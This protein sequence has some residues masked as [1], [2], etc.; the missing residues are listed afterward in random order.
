[1]LVAIGIAFGNTLSLI[2]VSVDGKVEVIAN[3]DGDRSIPLALL[4]VDGDEYHG[5]QA[6]AQLVRNP[7]NTVI[8]FR[9]LVGADE[10]HL[11]AAVEKADDRSAKPQLIDGVL[12]YKVNHEIVL[13]DEICARHFKQLKLAA[14]DYTGKTVGSVVLTVPTNFTAAQRERLAAVATGAGLPVAQLVLEPLAA[15]LA[16]V[17][18]T[19]TLD[20]DKTYVVADFGGV[21]SDAAV[22]AVRGGILTVLATAHDLHLGGALL[23]AALADH[24]AKEFTKK[25]KADARELARLAAKL[26][27]ECAAVK[28]TLLNVLTATIS[29]DLLAAGFDFHASV[30]RL[31]YELL[32]RQPLQ[33]MA[34]FVSVC[35]GKADLEPLDIDAVLL[36]GGVA[37][38]PKLTLLVGAAFEEVLTAVVDPSELNARGAA[39]QAA[40]IEPFDKEEIDASLEPV[41]VNSLH[42]AKPLGL[43]GADG[44][45]LPVVLAETA[46]PFR[47]TISLAA[48][49]NV[50]VQLVEGERT[51]K[52]TVEELPPRDEDDSESEEEPEVTRE[53]VYVPGN[54]VAEVG[55]DANGKVEVVVNIDRAGLL[56]LSARS[57]GSVAKVDVGHQ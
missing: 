34:D 27:A 52:E 40:L 4:Y 19:N 56:S 15:L 33:K 11:K 3:P 29:I 21:R 14:E 16:H 2:A 39:I 36:A 31:R 48:T 25:Y 5:A 35:A 17:A 54:K 12:L 10:A 41:V 47:K 22:V 6:L 42:T 9:D 55:I 18:A 46:I 51:V 8:N 13:V 37:N 26:V 57:G 30:N 23:D 49:G 53:V 20:Q 45:F 7:A 28:K 24:F 38:T 43:V 32:A 1:M 44:S 50:A